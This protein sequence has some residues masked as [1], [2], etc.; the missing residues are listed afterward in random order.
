MKLV[1]AVSAFGLVIIWWCDSV[2]EEG[3]LLFRLEWANPD[4]IL[5]TLNVSLLKLGNTS[6]C[7]P[8]EPKVCIFC[9]GA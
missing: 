4:H 8:S 9:C 3:P 7:K 2:V 5:S 1:L 6:S